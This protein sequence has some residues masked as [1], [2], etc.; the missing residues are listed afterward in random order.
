MRVVAGAGG[1]GGG[2]GGAT[3]VTAQSKRKVSRIAEIVCDAQK[4]LQ[5]ETEIR[6]GRAGQ[7]RSRVTGS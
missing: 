6:G 1:G 7:G 3:A 2:S 4:H 5:S